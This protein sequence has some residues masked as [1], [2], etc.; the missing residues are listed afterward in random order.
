MLNPNAALKRKVVY[1]YAGSITLRLFS[2][3]GTMEVIIPFIGIVAILLLIYY[4]Y[5]LM[6][7][8]EQ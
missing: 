8:D 6:K 1:S 5:I 7:G 4:I 2:K 3:G